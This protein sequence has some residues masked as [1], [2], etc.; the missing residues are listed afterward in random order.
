MGENLSCGWSG[1]W[2]RTLSVLEWF[3]IVKDKDRGSLM[4]MSPK[5]TWLHLAAGK[6]RIGMLFKF[7]CFHFYVNDAEISCKKHTKMS[8]INTKMICYN[9][10]INRL[11]IINAYLL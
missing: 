3:V 9:M 2:K 5:R 6:R 4:K 7:F 11:H 1:Q 8:Q 10:C